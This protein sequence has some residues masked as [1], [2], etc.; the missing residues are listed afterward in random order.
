MKSNAPKID[1]PLVFIIP[2]IVIVIIVFLLG[3]LFLRKKH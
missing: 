1:E 3:E 2:F